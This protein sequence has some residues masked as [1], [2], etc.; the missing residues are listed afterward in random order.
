MES[1][2]LEL[3][4][5]EMMQQ[6]GIKKNSIRLRVQTV[7]F[8]GAGEDLQ[9]PVQN[10]LSGLLSRVD[11]DYVNSDPTAILFSSG[12]S[13]KKALECIGDRRHVLLLAFAENNAYAAASEVKAFL[14]NKGIRA[15]LFNLSDSS[16]IENLHKLIEIW[17]RVRSFTHKKI[18]L[19]GRSSDWLVHSI[20]DLNE[21]RAKFGFRVTIFDWADLV[22][23]MEASKSK[24]FID[25]YQGYGKAEFENHSRIDSLLAQ[26]YHENELDGI[27]VEC[28]PLVKKH[29]LTACLSLARFNNI[30]MPAACEGDLISLVGMIFIRQLTGII[31]WMAN[32]SGVFAT[33]VEFTHCTVAP[34]QVE[35]YSITTHFE[36]NLGLAIAGVFDHEEQYTIFR[37]DKRFEQ[38]FIATGHAEKHES[39]NISCRTQLR[40]K[41]P[42]SD[43]KKLQHNPLGNHH[44]ILRGNWNEILI[45]ACEYL[46]L[47]II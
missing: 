43:T 22:D 2:K 40:L 1:W 18:G 11:V 36:T 12:G 5:G 32:L 6:K 14:E 24:D 35:E 31:P 8:E 23:P 33:H 16:R 42:D 19:V 13:E 34:D 9:M 27:A 21:L 15:Y 17:S 26:I 28:F 4:K 44:L 7:A 39:Q 10:R 3:I 25:Y 46:N 30:G 29:A 37:W 20:P 47:T 41:L 45:I 38:C